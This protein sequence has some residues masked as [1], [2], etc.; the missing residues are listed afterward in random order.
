[1]PGS[2]S[3]ST[4][5][6]KKSTSTNVQI[7]PV[8]SR[9]TSLLSMS[10]LILSSPPPATYAHD[11]SSTHTLVDTQEFDIDTVPTLGI[12]KGAPLKTYDSEIK[13]LEREFVDFGYV[14][15]NIEHTS[16]EDD[17]RLWSAQ[18]KS[19]VLAIVASTAMVC[20]PTP[21]MESTVLMQCRL[22]SS[23]GTASFPL[24]TPSRPSS[25]LPT[26]S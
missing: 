11:N 16:V 13:T 14:K 23:R 15:P 25:E 9:S 21:L 1:M 22:G 4:T 19:L 18:R 7:R 24:S 10:N 5:S 6:P 20:P 2:P 8:R 26:N 3:L 12:G 17:P